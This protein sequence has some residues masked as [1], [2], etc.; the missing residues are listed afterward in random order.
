MLAVYVVAHSHLLG[1]VD[2][3]FLFTE[4]ETR[5]H[6]SYL[7]YLEFGLFVSLYLIIFWPKS[8]ILENY[9]SS[10]LNS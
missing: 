9:S 3:V 1:G 6:F 2:K 10:L 8:F 5:K 4:D 7:W